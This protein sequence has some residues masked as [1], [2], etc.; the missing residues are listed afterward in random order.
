[1]RHGPRS[2]RRD[3]VSAN[4][5]DD[6]VYVIFGPAITYGIP[7]N[8]VPAAVGSVLSDTIGCA[9]RRGGYERY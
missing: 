3:T 7:L 4:A 6:M 5:L 9:A 2:P 1:M 8:A